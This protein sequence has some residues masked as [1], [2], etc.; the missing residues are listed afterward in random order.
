MAKLWQQ[1]YSAKAAD[2]EEHSIDLPA[3]KE[4]R[5]DNDGIRGTSIVLNNPYPCM[6]MSQRVT[7]HIRNVRLPPISPQ[8][9][10]RAWR[11][12][13]RKSQNPMNR[14]PIISM[15]RR[16]HLS[17]QMIAGTEFA[18]SSN[19]SEYNNDQLRTRKCYV[20]DVL[21]RLTVISLASMMG[22]REQLTSA[23]R[24]LR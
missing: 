14:V 18:I 3:D 21:H 9:P 5:T 2:N 23:M 24:L 8:W 15:G 10:K 11:P 7:R 19:F 1:F 4:V 12:P 13:T 20:E 16:P 6:K 22:K 17:M